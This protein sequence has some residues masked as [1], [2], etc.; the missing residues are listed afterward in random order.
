MGVEE[1]VRL[2]KNARPGETRHETEIIGWKQA[3]G[4]RENEGQRGW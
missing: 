3:D 1:F 4:E 2:E